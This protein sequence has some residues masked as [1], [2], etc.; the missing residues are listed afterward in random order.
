MK[1]WRIGELGHTRHTNHLA[2]TSPDKGRRG[3]SPD[4]RHRGLF[5]EKYR[6]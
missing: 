4:K 2:G 6:S 5:T 3:L 1:N